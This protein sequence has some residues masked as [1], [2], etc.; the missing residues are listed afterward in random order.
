MQ[1]M[2]INMADQI[3]QMICRMKGPDADVFDLL[4]YYTDCSVLKQIIQFTIC[5]SMPEMPYFLQA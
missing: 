2:L 3:E 1:K 4:P 5:S